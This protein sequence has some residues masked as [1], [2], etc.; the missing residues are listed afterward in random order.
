[1]IKYFFLCIF[2]LV[3]VFAKDQYEML[4]ESYNKFEINVEEIQKTCKEKAIF[5]TYFLNELYKKIQNDLF[6]IE[7]DTKIFVKNYMRKINS[8]KINE[9][10][11]EVY[12]EYHIIENKYE[13]QKSSILENSKKIEIYTGFEQKQLIESVTKILNLIE[14]IDAEVS[15]INSLYFSSIEKLLKPNFLIKNKIFNKE[16]M[17]KYI[18]KDLDNLR[19]KMIESHKEID[20]LESSLDKEIKT[21]EEIVNKIFKNESL[22]NKYKEFIIGLLGLLGGGLLGSIVINK[23]KYIQRNEKNTQ[24][25]N[26]PIN[27]V[28]NKKQE[29]SSI[30][31]ISGLTINDATVLFDK[32]IEYN[33]PKLVD[34]ASEKVYKRLDEFKIELFT[35]I[36]NRDPNGFNKFN[37]PDIQFSLNECQKSYAKSGKSEL[38]KLLIDLFSKKL[39]TEDEL[40]NVLL[41]E[42]ITIAP[43]ITND[44][45][46]ILKDLY[47]LNNV[48]Y[49]I[50]TLESFKDFYLNNTFKYKYSDI[51]H[52]IYLGLIR[53]NMTRI[54]IDE[55]LLENN[56]IYVFNKGFLNTDMSAEFN[57]YVNKNQLITQNKY[58]PKRMEFIEDVKINDKFL[59]EARS[60]F[61][62]GKMNKGE[63]INLLNSNGISYTQISNN[64][65]NSDFS[66]HIFAQM[67]LII[68]KSYLESKN[69]EP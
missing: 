61:T 44:Q 7:K 37:Q 40:E 36:E 34:E 58:F 31:N 39:L 48:N 47:F 54:D 69:R 68:V 53:H 6:S 43:K 4:N 32:L 62:A 15:K 55:Y 24:I 64:F 66:H 56:Y 45:I 67:G 60:L 26:D 9:E 57:D 33:L 30:V 16:E 25:Y 8:L 65:K 52:L 51:T 42:A 22:W 35:A 29:A 59:S 20:V 38:K 13:K 27:T 46:E 10:L 1:M 2:L 50:S 41:N 19:N 5:E 12:K 17:I 28:D 23:N 49:T 18:M 14:K 21:S 11:K 3:N 63:I